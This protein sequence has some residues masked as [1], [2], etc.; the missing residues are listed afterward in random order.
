MKRFA[1][2]SLFF[3]VAIMILKSFLLSESTE[4]TEQSTHDH[5]SEQENKAVVSKPTLTLHES[6][7]FNAHEVNT[8]A[9]G[10]ADSA[11][12]QSY[13]ELTE[14]S[15][16]GRK[17]VT[18]NFSETIDDVISVV[19]TGVSGQVLPQ[20]IK[21]NDGHQK[22]LYLGQ[23]LFEDDWIKIDDFQGK[24]NSINLNLIAK[25][26]GSLKI[27]LQKRSTP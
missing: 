4:V 15:V 21:V 3:V 9:P 19:I 23:E 16:A 25:Q 8:L 20:T 17:N 1:F 22:N 18:I 12:G 2:V 24:L 13:R 5:Q 10:I 11:F 6:M 7:E 14:I 27:Y 26:S